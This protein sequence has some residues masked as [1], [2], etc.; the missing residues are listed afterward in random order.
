VSAIAASLARIRARASAPASADEK[1][2]MASA[3]GSTSRRDVSFQPALHPK[4]Y[5]AAEP[6]AGPRPVDA[7]LPRFRATRAQSI[8]VPLSSTSR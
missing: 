3:L 5:L 1:Y 4:I 2:A 8:I 7:I 6:A